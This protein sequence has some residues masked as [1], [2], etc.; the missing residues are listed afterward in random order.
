MLVLSYLV[1]SFVIFIGSGV[2]PALVTIVVVAIAIAIACLF[3]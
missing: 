3:R 2:V 1:L